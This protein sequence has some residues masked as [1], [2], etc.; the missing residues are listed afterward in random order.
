MNED[1][2]RVV[3]LKTE[4][5]QWAR[6]GGDLKKKKE[7]LIEIKII[8]KCEKVLLNHQNQPLGH[9]LDT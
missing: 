6:I 5:N 8:Q 4:R 3:E 1:V 7:A 9:T 2:K